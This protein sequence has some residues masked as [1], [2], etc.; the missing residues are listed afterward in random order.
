MT[1]AQFFAKLWEF[2]IP[3]IVGVAILFL[4]MWAARAALHDADFYECP[5]GN[6]LVVCAPGTGPPNND[7]RAVGSG[8]TTIVPRNCT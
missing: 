7:C 5:P 3:A 4:G 6:T 1:L 2:A 8:K